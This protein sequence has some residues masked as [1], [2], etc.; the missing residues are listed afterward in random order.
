V[1]KKIRKFR[2]VEVRCSEAGD[3]EITQVDFDSKHDCRERGDLDFDWDFDQVTLSVN[4]E[5]GRSP[6]GEWY[7]GERHNG[8]RIVKLKL[9]R[10]S[11]T[12]ITAEDIDFYIGF[13]LNKEQYAELVEYLNI[14]FSKSKTLEIREDEV[15]T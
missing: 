5:F 1:V 15:T 2:A 10:N 13:E 9:T 3:F 7:D 12:I 4:F 11:V 8:G 14:V 6:K